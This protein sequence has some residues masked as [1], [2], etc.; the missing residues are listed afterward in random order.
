M[1]DALTRIWENLGG[2]IGGPMTLRLFLQPA[3]SIFFAVRDGMR[4][5][6]EGNPAYLWA[7]ASVPSH[8]RELLRNGWKSVSKVFFMAL[9]IDFVYQIRVFERVYPGELVIVALLLA[10]VPYLLLRGPV[11]RITRRSVHHGHAD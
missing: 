4:D 10:L 1:E 2:R 9:L 5:A 7:V 8:R 11:T 6:R 3:M